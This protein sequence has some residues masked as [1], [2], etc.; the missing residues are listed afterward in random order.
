[1]RLSAGAAAAAGAVAAAALATLVFAP[2]LGA[3]FV[4]DDFFLLD[5]VVS[6]GPFGA[7]TRNTNFF[8]P[9]A[10]ASL[11]L[12]HRAWGLVPLPFHALRQRASTFPSHG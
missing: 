3:F 9:L 12:D 7:W 4:A 11:W 6:G 1:M 2:A 5:A 8:R 10:S